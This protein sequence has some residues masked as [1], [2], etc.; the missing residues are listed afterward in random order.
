MGRYRDEEHRNR[1]LKSY[2]IERRFYEKLTPLFMSTQQ[3]SGFTV[4]MSYAHVW[5]ATGT[6]GMLQCLQ[7]NSLKFVYTS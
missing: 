2:Q 4:P 3:A 5:N 1:S 7:C 6:E